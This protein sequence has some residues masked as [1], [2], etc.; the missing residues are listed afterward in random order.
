MHI[1]SPLWFWKQTEMCTHVHTSYK[2]THCGT[3]DWVHWL[4]DLCNRSVGWR[5]TFVVCLN[6]G[7]DW[8]SRKGPR[9]LG[10]STVF[11]RRL[12]VR[13][14]SRNGMQFTHRSVSVMRPWKSLVRWP[15]DLSR[16]IDPGHPGVG[17]GSDLSWWHG[18]H[19]LWG[20]HRTSVDYLT[21]ANDT[22][23]WFL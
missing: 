12:A 9:P 21:K 19:F 16:L 17:S 3:W 15:L 2:M 23:L 14:H 13:L 4:W 5:Q 6:M 18:R 10:I 22:E 7:W 11:Q 1:A 20:I 8:L